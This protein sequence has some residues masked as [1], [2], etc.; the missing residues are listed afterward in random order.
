MAYLIIHAAVC[1]LGVFS[2]LG[3]ALASMSSPDIWVS[4]VFGAVR[5]SLFGVS[6]CTDWD[7]SCQFYEKSEVLS[8]GPPTAGLVVARGASI[9]TGIPGGFASAASGAAE[10]KMIRRKEV[11]EDADVAGSLI[12][13]AGAV[14]WSQAVETTRMTFP[15]PRLKTRG[16]SGLGDIW[17][18]PLGIFFISWY[19]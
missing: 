14:P 5:Q 13:I 3:I 6:E 16:R 7:H 10:D 1:H 12:Y 15:I 4:E 17:A 11:S 9:G 19:M 2:T 8:K 18:E